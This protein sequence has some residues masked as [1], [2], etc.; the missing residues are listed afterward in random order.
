MKKDDYFYG[1]HFEALGDIWDALYCDAEA[2]AKDYVEKSVKEGIVFINQKIKNNKMYGLFYP[3]ISTVQIVSY[4]RELKKHSLTYISSCPVL[5]GCKN[6]LILKK[7][8]TWTNGI[9]G[10]F[11]AESTTENKLLLNFFDPFYC[12]D[13]KY[14][15][16][17]NCVE[18]N[19]AAVAYTAN[20]LEER[21]DVIDK[22]EFY[23]LKLKEFLEENPDKTEM[24]FEPPIVHTS[25]EHFR[26]Y[27]PTDTTSVV[28]IV[29]LVEDISYCK[30]LGKNFAV[31]KVNLEHRKDD[32]YLYIDVY[33]SE[34]LLEKYKPEIGK[35]LHSIVWL[36]GFFDP[37]SMQ[38]KKEI[39]NVGCMIFLFILLLL[40]IILTFLGY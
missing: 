29:G 23:K 38:H 5:K 1:E 24:D 30:Y 33:V 15:D 20:E 14:F 31:L 19:L 18:V 37:I 8:Y 2:F 17:N 21:E 13:Q 16:K 34:Q 40:V 7:K 3:D 6:K 39:N 26:M 36:N 11:A 25:S 27:T 12:V 4:L 10:E 9:E 35:G 22:G 32:E 28:E